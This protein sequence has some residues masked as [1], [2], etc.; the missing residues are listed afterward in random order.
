M[1]DIVL[2]DEDFGYISKNQ[3]ESLFTIGLVF[4]IAVVELF[5][6]CIYVKQWGESD[7]VIILCSFCLLK[8]ILKLRKYLISYFNKYINFFIICFFFVM[9]FLLNCILFVLINFVLFY[10]FIL[11]FIRKY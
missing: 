8:K 11:V 3:I 7:L 2:D 6:V 1:F 4:D 5:F 10:F 9:Y